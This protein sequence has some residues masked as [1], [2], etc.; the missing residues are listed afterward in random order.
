MPP[1]IK[2]GFSFFIILSNPFAATPILF[3]ELEVIT[4]VAFNLPVCL[5]VFKH[6]YEWCGPHTGGKVLLVCMS[7]P[8]EV[9][10]SLFRAGQSA[11]IGVAPSHCHSSPPVAE[12][13]GSI[14]VRGVAPARCGGA[15]DLTVSS[16]MPACSRRQLIKRIN[17]LIPPLVDFY[18][19]VYTPN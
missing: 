16:L 10:T 1:Q 14:N 19:S 18:L 15:G 17:P 12:N 8:S 2:H 4:P 9:S 6:Y 7:I 11:T 3:F 5:T 13:P